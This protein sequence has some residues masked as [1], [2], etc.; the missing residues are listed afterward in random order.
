MGPLVFVVSYKAAP[1]RWNGR[2]TTPKA[3]FNAEQL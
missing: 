2:G 3:D 1:H